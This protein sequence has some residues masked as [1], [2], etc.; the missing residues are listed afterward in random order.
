MK[1]YTMDQL[2]Y[3]VRRAIDGNDLASVKEPVAGNV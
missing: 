2:A 3:A 1:P